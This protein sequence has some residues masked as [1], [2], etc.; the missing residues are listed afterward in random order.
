MT[1][2]PVESLE[3]TMNIWN[4]KYPGMILTHYRNY[5]RKDSFKTEKG[6]DSIA[7]FEGWEKSWRVE[8]H[9]RTRSPTHPT[10]DIS[11]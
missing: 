1:L 3:K 7:A 5:D 6:A 8:T 10:T 4:E 9:E 11:V 2:D